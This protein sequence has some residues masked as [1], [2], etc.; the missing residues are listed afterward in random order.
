MDTV[1][2]G[3]RFFRGSVLV[4]TETRVTVFNIRRVNMKMCFSHRVT[5][6]LTQASGVCGGGTSEEE[7]VCFYFGMKRKKKGSIN[8][9]SVAE[10][11]GNV[12]SNK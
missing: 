10:L 1:A 11:G 4:L 3:S 12:T 9:E 8:N 5:Y 6:I 7:E 2:S